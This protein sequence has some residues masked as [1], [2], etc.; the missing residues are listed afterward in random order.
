M[1]SQWANV[2]VLCVL[3]LLL[4]AQ[5]VTAKDKCSWWDYTCYVVPATVGGVAAVAG[6]PLVLGE[7]NHDDVYKKKSVF[8]IRLND[9]K[10]N[11]RKLKK[12][13]SS[14]CKGNGTG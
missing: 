3:C 5:V 6:A 4:T 1:Q 13:Y 10:K 8:L 9:I 12:D 7:N 2:K 14:K 11:F